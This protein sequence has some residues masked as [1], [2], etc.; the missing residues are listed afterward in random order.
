M[1]GWESTKLFEYLGAGLPILATGGSGNDAVLEI[2]SS[3]G[4]GVYLQTIDSVCE[5]LSS[6]FEQKTHGLKRVDE[7]SLRYAFSN[8]SLELDIYL[9]QLLSDFHK[10]KN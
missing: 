1:K 6:A 10:T 8:Q 4:A 3:T 2:L 7:P 9:R 5:F